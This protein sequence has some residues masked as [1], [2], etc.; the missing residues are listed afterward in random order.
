MSVPYMFVFLKG[1]I[2]ILFNYIFSLSSCLSVAKT[3]EKQHYLRVEKH[4]PDS[5]CY[6]HGLQSLGVRFNDNSFL[7]IAVSFEN[8]RETFNCQ[9]DSKQQT[10]VDIKDLFTPLNSG[11]PSYTPTP[12]SLRIS[13]HIAAVCLSLTSDNSGFCFFRCCTLR[14]IF[15]EFQCGDFEQFLAQ[16]VFRFGNMSTIKSVCCLEEFSDGGNTL[17]L[18]SILVCAL[19]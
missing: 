17:I 3:I 14:V 12:L 8:I 10:L 6:N 18:S 11:G 1:F 13:Q 16:E 5:I 9:V 2:T 4:L 19:L 7:L 15:K